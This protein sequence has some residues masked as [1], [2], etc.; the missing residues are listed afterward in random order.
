MRKDMKRILVLRARGGA[1]W[2][3]KGRRRAPEDLPRNEPMSRGRGSKRLSE[4]LAPLR[5]FL[6]RRVGE[7]W[8][9]V[10]SEICAHVRRDNAVQKHI[11]DHLW[12]MVEHQPLF[13]DGVAHHPFHTWRDAARI[14]ASRW[15]PFHVSEHGI[16]V[17]S[18]Q[19]PHRRRK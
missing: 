3:R 4:N 10:Y 11:L 8:D 7:R 12:G 19:R 17:R 14:Y 1:G 15:S 16:L 18:P 6:E 13:I 5:R 2:N 9:N